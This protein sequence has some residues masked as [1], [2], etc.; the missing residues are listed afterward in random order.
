MLTTQAEVD[1]ALLSGD[2]EEIAAALQMIQQGTAPYPSWGRP[3][4]LGTPDHLKPEWLRTG[5][6]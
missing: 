3:K 6:D 5:V 1:K 4:E 2:P